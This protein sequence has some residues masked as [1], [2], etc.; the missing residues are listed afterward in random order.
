VYSV[1]SLSNAGVSVSDPIVS[2][3]RVAVKGFPELRLWC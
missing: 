2:P 3:D 1:T